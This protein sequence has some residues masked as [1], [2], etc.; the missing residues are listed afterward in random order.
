MRSGPQAARGRDV[1][2]LADALGLEKPILGG[3]DWGGMPPVWRR[4]YW[5]ER[6]GGL[7]SIRG[8]RALSISANNGVLFLPR[9][10]ASAGISI[11]FRPI[12]DSKAWPSI[13][14]TWCR[15]LWE[16]WSPGWHFDEETFDRTAG[17]FDNP[18]FCGS[19]DSLLPPQLIGLRG[20]SRVAATR[21]SIDKTA[22]HNGAGGDSWM[23]RSIHSN[24]EERRIT[25]PCSPRCM[26]IAFS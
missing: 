22:S 15:L 9:S 4:L 6:I 10:N 13:A 3:F 19:G 23:A 7:V 2:E 25:P 20:R 21:R 12:A 8:L 17:A 18:D 11:F 26:N 5:P 24:R 14:A 1:V 16:E